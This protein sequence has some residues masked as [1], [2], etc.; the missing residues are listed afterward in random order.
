M[1]CG[2]SLAGTPQRSEPVV[3]AGRRNV[4]NDDPYGL[5]YRLTEAQLSPVAAR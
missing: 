5:Y 1:R 4:L 3:V 2:N